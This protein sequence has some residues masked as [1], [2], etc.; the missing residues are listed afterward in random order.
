MSPFQSFDAVDQ[1]MADEQV[2]NPQAVGNIVWP[3]ADNLGTVRD[4]AVS[5][6]GITSVANHR[7][8]DSF[9]NLKSQ[10]NATVDCLF[11]FTGLLF[12]KAT[13]LN[14]T[15]TRPYEAPT[16][17]FIQED[18][19][20]LTGGDTNLYR[21]CCN[22]PTD[23]TDPTGK[24]WWNLWIC[25][26]GYSLGDRIGTGYAALFGNGFDLELKSARLRQE[27]AVREMSDPNSRMTTKQFADE[28]LAVLQHGLSEAL[29]TAY[30]VADGALAAGEL[31]VAVV[32]VVVDGAAALEAA[33]GLTGRNVIQN[34]GNEIKQWLGNDLRMI[35]NDAGDKIFVSKDGLRRVQFHFNNTAPHTSPHVH[36]DVK[37]G[38]TW[39]KGRFYPNDVPP[40]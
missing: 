25:D 15:D 23:R 24:A 31:T 37:V 17:R 9:G 36:I 16:G 29:N 27:W 3:L 28:R 10:T 12:D 33:E 11:G 40:H 34:L 4:L 32:S 22:S 18:K 5:Q 20:G 8:F 19:I 39:K 14:M 30:R 38:G 13:G 1:L 6:N 26:L 21:Y 2:T 7:V 35:V